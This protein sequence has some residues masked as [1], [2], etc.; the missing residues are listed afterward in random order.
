MKKT[1]LLF[2]A[3]VISVMFVSCDSMGLRPLSY[4]TFDAE[5]FIEDYNSNLARTFEKYIG[6]G[7]QCDVTI[8][9]ISKD[10]KTITVTVGSDYIHNS[11][12]Y[13]YIVQGEVQI[14]CEILDRGDQKKILEVN[15][16]DKIFIEGRIT[17]INSARKL[18]MDIHKIEIQ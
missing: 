18:E 16:G 8:K 3:I 1:L 2:L 15:K 7:Y 11:G 10:D 17:D 9:D 4:E 14:E 13:G 6:N 5:A 12:S